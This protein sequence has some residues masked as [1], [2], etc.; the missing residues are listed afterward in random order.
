MGRLIY[1]VIMY[2]TRF[3]ASG[4]HLSGHTRLLLLY[5][6]IVSF[7]LQ[8][9]IHHQLIYTEEQNHWLHAALTYHASED[10]WDEQWV[11]A[12]DGTHKQTGSSGLAPWWRAA[13]WDV[14]GG[15]VGAS[16]GLVRGRWR[17][18]DPWL[19]SEATWD[20]TYMLPHHRQHRHKQTLYL[21][22]RKEKQG[23]SRGGAG[24]IRGGAPALL[25][26]TASI[27]N[28]EENIIRDQQLW[29]P[30]IQTSH[31]LNWTVLF[32]PP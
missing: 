26:R 7:K 30:C 2:F 4:K 31:R 8:K 22:L 23:Q 12:L 28:T 13:V 32:Y 27:S 10:K 1:N 25:V 17:Q 9:K 20:P 3:C 14:Q 15:P 24:E 18:G 5:I 6:M 19:H 16:G 29:Q 11:G 21:G